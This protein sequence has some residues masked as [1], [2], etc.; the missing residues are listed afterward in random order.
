MVFGKSVCRFL[1]DESGVVTVDWVA[2]TAGVVILGAL[3]SNAVMSGANDLGTAISV[4]M[5]DIS[6][7]DEI[8]QIAERF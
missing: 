5:T 4:E 2:I 1:N 6:E 8:T 3:I 7:S